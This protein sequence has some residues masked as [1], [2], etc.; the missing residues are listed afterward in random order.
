VLRRA[1][2]L[3]PDTPAASRANKQLEQLELRSQS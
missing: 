3:F 1:V 2:S